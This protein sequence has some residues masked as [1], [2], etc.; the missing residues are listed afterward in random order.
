MTSAVRFVACGRVGH[1]TLRNSPNASR[2]NP[3]LIRS[4]RRLIFP[5]RA[6]VA[7]HSP[8]HR[9]GRRHG[10]HDTSA[11]LVTAVGARCGAT[12]SCASSHRHRKIPAVLSLTGNLRLAMR[13][14]LAAT[15]AVLPERHPIR[16][17]P[18][19]LGRRVVWAFALRAFQS[20][21]DPVFPL[22]HVTIPLDRDTRAGTYPSQWH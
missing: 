22:R 13:L 1:V 15:R 11:R 4:L 19:V 9:L 3:V 14:M 10:G 5:G 2:K 16:V 6:G 12:L 8:A 20:E 17:I 21:G 18:T 7:A